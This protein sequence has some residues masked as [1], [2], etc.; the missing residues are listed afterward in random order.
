MHVISFLLSMSKE[1]KLESSSILNPNHLFLKSV[2][3]VVTFV[4]LNACLYRV[5]IFCFVVAEMD[6]DIG[7]LVSSGHLPG[8]FPCQG[9]CSVGRG[10]IPTNRPFQPSW[11]AVH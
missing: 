11:G 6:G 5:F 3:L 10:K 7:S 2:R 8:H 9:Y 1:I 4:V